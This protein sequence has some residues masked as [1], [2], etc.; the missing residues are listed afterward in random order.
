MATM[1]Q[2]VET[3]N[4]TAVRDAANRARQISAMLSDDAQKRVTDAIDIAREAAR[5]MVK[6]AKAGEQ[7][8]REIDRAAIDRIRDARL[9]FLDVEET[10]APAVEDLPE[11]ARALDLEAMPV[12]LQI[13]EVQAPAFEVPEARIPG[14]FDSEMARRM[15]RADLEV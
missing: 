3:L 10:A 9:S 13:S 11:V 5:K 6:A 4:A 7:A 15:D 14:T 1:A 12:A 8:A 2:G